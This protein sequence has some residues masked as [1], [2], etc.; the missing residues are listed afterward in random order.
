[1]LNPHKSLSKLRRS[2]KI[3][4]I[5]LFKKKNIW[6]GEDIDRAYLVVSFKSEHSFRYATP[7]QPSRR[8]TFDDSTKKK[9]KN[10]K[11]FLIT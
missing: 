6:K 4:E 1:M 10:E 8:S 3:G 5:D 9:R 11:N 7:L 2:G